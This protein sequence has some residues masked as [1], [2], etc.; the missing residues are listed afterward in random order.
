MK[1]LI[2]LMQGLLPFD[3]TKPR[4]STSTCCWSIL[5][6]SVLI[7][8]AGHA[9]DPGFSRLLV[10]LDPL[11]DRSATKNRTRE[12]PAANVKSTKRQSQRTRT[13]QVLR[14]RPAP[15]KHV[16]QRPVHVEWQKR[17][18]PFK[19]ELSSCFLSA[20]EE[21]H[22]CTW[23]TNMTDLSQ[24]H[25]VVSR[26]GTECTGG[27]HSLGGDFPSPVYTFKLNRCFFFF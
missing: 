7:L 22:S 4:F 20:R 5:K 9:F 14:L 25:R 1:D 11:D 26:G 23:T 13:S 27:R 3:K 10:H 16:L 6:A 8:F 21:M 18:P 15:S 24:S 19:M 17:H 12:K 2:G